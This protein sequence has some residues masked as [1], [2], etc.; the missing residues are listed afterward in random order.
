[1]MRYAAV[2]KSGTADAESILGRFSR[3]A[4][5]DGGSPMHPAYRAVAELGKAVKTVF[6]C[7]DIW[8]R[9]P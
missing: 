4:P 8:A 6:L 9:K 7:T 2:L 1:M 3:G 5:G